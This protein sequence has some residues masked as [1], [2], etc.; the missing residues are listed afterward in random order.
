MYEK[1]EKARGGYVHIYKCVKHLLHSMYERTC[2]AHETTI[3]KM[4]EIVEIFN[5]EIK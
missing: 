2:A 4:K 3:I 1:K 5:S